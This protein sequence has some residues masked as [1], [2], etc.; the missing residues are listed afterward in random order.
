M[1]IA[2]VQGRSP[3]LLSASTTRGTL[4]HPIVCRAVA[5][6]TYPRRSD[7]NMASGEHSFMAQPA[8]PPAPSPLTL[9]PSNGTSYVPAHA[10][11]HAQTWRLT[12]PETARHRS[13]SR[14]AIPHSGDSAPVEHARVSL[15]RPCASLCRLLFLREKAEELRPYSFA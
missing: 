2:S 1:V 12:T 10:R 3:L 7:D 4:Q 15:P 6:P 8:Q 13:R 11:R 14:P 9:Q 5:T